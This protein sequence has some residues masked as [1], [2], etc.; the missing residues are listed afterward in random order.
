MRSVCF[1]SPA[2]DAFFSPSPITPRRGSLSLHK[3]PS[4]TLDPIGINQNIPSSSSSLSSIASGDASKPYFNPFLLLPA[5]LVISEK[6]T[7]ERGS[8]SSSSFSTSLS[9][10]A[11]S[12]Q[13]DLPPPSSLPPQKEDHLLSRTVSDFRIHRRVS[14]FS[15][16][17]VIPSVPL[18]D[19]PPS[20]HVSSPSQDVERGKRNLQALHQGFLMVRMGKKTPKKRWCVLT[21]SQFA[22]FEDSSRVATDP[23]LLV[24]LLG[25]AVKFSPEKPKEFSLFSSNGHSYFFV[26]ETKSDVSQWVPQISAVC[27]KLVLSSINSNPDYADVTDTQQFSGIKERLISLLSIAGNDVCADCGSPNPEWASINLGIF[28]CLD[29]S[30]V[31]RSLGSHVSKVRSVYLDDWAEDSVQSIQEI[32][33]VNSNAVFEL[34]IPPSIQKPAKDTPRDLREH[35]IRLKYAKRLFTAAPDP[36]EEVLKGQI[37]R[38]LYFDEEFRDEIRQI[39]TVQFPASPKIPKKMTKNDQKP[40]K[41]K[42]T[43]AI[44]IPTEKGILF[45]GIP[46]SARKN[47]PEIAEMKEPVLCS[48]QG[49]PSGVMGIVG[50]P[51]SPRSLLRSHSPSV[52][53]RSNYSDSPSESGRKALRTTK[54]FSN[55]DH[56]PVR[57]R[58]IFNP[59]GVNKMDGNLDDEEEDLADPR[60]LP[61]DNDEEWVRVYR[62][63][64]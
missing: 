53:A 32:G 5:A 29:C 8:S 43:Y 23:L 35:F 31:H 20:L 54:I 26:S 38:M 64:F 19:H 46:N 39:L 22:I 59:K 51:L 60:R 16:P 24:E 13:I 52:P 61:D 40:G 3:A 1:S 12:N 50:N 15:S 2:H 4:S 45:S 18:S 7:E 36:Y 57:I 47:P 62:S 17:Q 42:E 55:L 30:G 33:N 63:L 27:E 58:N 34:Y 37:I 56:G 21:E 6:E 11:I 9:S 49:M 44:P 48:G 14:K 41:K 25:G 28:I 10:S